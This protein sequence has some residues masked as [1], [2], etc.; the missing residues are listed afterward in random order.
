[1]NIKKWIFENIVLPKIT[2]EVKKFMEN[3]KW[4]ESKTIWSGIIS[5]VIAI[6]NTVQPLLSQ[7]FGI[8]LPVIPDWIYTVLGSLGI[9]GRITANK[10]IK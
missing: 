7:F 4:Y 3:K 5:I 9:Y 1:M 2:K 10:E 8:N 6:Y